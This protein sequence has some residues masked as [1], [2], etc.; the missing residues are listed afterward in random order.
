MA[1]LKLHN[2]TCGRK[3]SE[4]SF[5]CS[6]ILKYGGE[7]KFF[8]ESTAANDDDEIIKSLFKLLNDQSLKYYAPA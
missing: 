7:E 2:E 3:A 5:K 1:E 4:T 8:A 6:G